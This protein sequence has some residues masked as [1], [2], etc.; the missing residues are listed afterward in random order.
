[1]VNNRAKIALAV[2]INDCNSERLL[3]SSLY[4]YLKTVKEKT[5]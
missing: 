5:R 1:M 2:L 3:L 4:F